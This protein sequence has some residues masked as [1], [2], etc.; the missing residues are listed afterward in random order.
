ML[1]SDPARQHVAF[2]PLVFLAG[3]VAFGL[4]GVL[5]AME[6][7]KDDL[8]GDLMVTG[9]AVF[10]VAWFILNIRFARRD[11]D[12]IMLR[13]V[14]GSCRV[15]VEGSTIGIVQGGAAASPHLDVLLQPD[16]GEPLRLARLE[17]V[18][19]GRAPAVAREIAAALRLPVDEQT[20]MPVEAQLAG[21]APKR[22]PLKSGSLGVIAIAAACIIGSFVMLYLDD[23]ATIRFR[24]AD[25]IIESGG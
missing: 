24:C 18:G 17:I 25:G 8:L 10:G 21:V 6:G 7:A 3:G 4:L 15:P 23:A 16:R 1:I 12:E 5:V 20:V 13:S 11:G 2:F 9:A 14:L 19:V 22:R